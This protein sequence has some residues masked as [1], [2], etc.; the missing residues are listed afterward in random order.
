M[1]HDNN[2]HFWGMHFLWWIF[3]ILIAAYIFLTPYRI[4]GEKRPKD[5]PLDILNKR[6]ARGEITKEEFEEKKK[7]L[8]NNSATQNTLK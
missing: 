8:E 2:E 7:F 5:S 3:W 6:F 4:P 1:W